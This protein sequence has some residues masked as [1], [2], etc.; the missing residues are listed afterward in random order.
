MVTKTI[1]RKITSKGQITIPLEIRKILGGDIVTFVIGQENNI[2]LTP[3]DMSLE[4]AFGS[5]AVPSHLQGISEKEI[6]QILQDDTLDNFQSKNR[7]KSKN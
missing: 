7:T 2:T 1:T 6:Q 3:V 4:E 5:V